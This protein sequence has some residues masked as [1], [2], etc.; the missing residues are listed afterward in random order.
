MEATD[1]LDE[2]VLTHTYWQEAMNQLYT[3][4]MT[5]GL[6]IASAILVLFVGF[7]IIGKV[8]KGI[9]LFIIKRTDDIAVGEFIEK[10]A[11]II[12]K[13]MLFLSVATQVGIETTSFVAALGAAG[14]AIGMAL[15]GSLSNFAGGVLILIFKPFRVGDTIDSQGFSGE[16]TKIDILHTK[17]ITGDNRLVILPNGPVANSSIVNS[18]KQDK[19]RSEFLIN[20]GYQ[21]QIQDVREVILQTLSTDERILKSPACTVVVNAL[22]DSS[23]QLLVRFWTENG[24]HS[25]A[26]ASALEN[27]KTA[28]DQK[29]IIIPSGPQK[30]ELIGK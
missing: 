14:L 8:A 25:G 11:S 20:V 21:Y 22:N 4:L 16:V 19:R 2:K 1:L 23:I 7:F 27:V 30:I 6:D 17:L 10:T 12:M 5:K 18:T 29:G 28:F 26:L 9:R 15:Q 24:Q 3:L 13:V